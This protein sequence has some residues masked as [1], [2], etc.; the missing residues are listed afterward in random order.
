MG[1]TGYDDGNFWL[2]VD[3]APWM[4]ALSGSGFALVVL[5]YLYLLLTMLFW[6]NRYHISSFDQSV[7]DRVNS[8][9]TFLRM[10]LPVS[11]VLT[12]RRIRAKWENLAGFYGKKRKFWVGDAD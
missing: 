10:N 3:A 12:W 8:L 2:I 5:G 11:L 9:R 7:R 1:T 6:R 4:T